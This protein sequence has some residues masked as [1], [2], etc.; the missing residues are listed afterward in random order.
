M[1]VLCVLVLCCGGKA[2]FVV[3]WFV[4][5]GLYGCG[6]TRYNFVVES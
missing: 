6:S 2:C 3:L 5:C 4:W 1:V